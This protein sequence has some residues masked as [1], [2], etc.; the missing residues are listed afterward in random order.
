MHA[1]IIYSYVP[2]HNHTLTSTFQTLNYSVFKT[3]LTAVLLCDHNNNVRHIIYDLK[4]VRQNDL[5]SVK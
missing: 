2:T 1:R 4:T 5:Q 3:F